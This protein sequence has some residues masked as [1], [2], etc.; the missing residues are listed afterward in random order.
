[1]EHLYIWDSFLPPRWQDDIED[2]Q[3]LEVLHP[4][5]NVK[6]LYISR[7]LTPFIA[8]ALQELVG[9][10]VI[11]VLPALQILF[12]GELH[13]SG[14]VQEAIGKFVAARQLTGHPVILSHWDGK[15]SFQ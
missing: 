7:E 11:E 10:R 5:T 14:P 12:L 15:T 3:W 6:F 8:H 9:E 4:F 1:M 2:G 13:L